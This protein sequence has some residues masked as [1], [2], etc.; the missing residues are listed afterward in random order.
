MKIILIVMVLVVVAVERPWVLLG[1]LAVP[2]AVAPARIVLSGAKG[3][4]LI[5]VL[6]ATGRLQLAY[7]LFTA[8]GLWI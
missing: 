3:V 4:A 5:R 2:L 8:I 1:L 7:G 6:A